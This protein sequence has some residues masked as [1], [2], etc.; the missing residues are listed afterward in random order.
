MAAGNGLFFFTWQNMASS[1]LIFIPYSARRGIGSAMRFVAVPPP[2]LDLDRRPRRS[3]ARGQGRLVGRRTVL[4]GSARVARRPGRDALQPGAPLSGAHRRLPGE[5]RR[6]LAG[7]RPAS[8]TRAHA[9]AWPAAPTGMGASLTACALALADCATGGACRRV[10]RG[11]LGHATVLQPGLRHKRPNRRRRRS[12]GAPGR[13]HDTAGRSGAQPV[14]QLR[15]HT[16]A[17][18]DDVANVAR[19]IV[20]ACLPRLPGRRPVARSFGGLRD[21][22]MPDGRGAAS[23]RAGPPAATSPQHATLPAAVRS[24]TVR[25]VNAGATSRAMGTGTLVEIDQQS[26]TGCHLRTCFATGR[27]RF[28]SS[29]PTDAL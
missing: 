18:A 13:S 16:D 29:F 22:S 6:P 5:S 15:L 19:S 8:A 1:D 11:R 3:F 7:V 12:G 26:G 9:A 24:A 21:G 10:R 17:I 27:G 2:R 23:R 28:A 20:I 14:L 4:P 25:V